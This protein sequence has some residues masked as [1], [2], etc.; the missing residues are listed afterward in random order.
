M[1]DGQLII[2]D[3]QC[4]IDKHA[5]EGA[6]GAQKILDDRLVYKSFEEFHQSYPHGIRIALSART[7]KNR[8]SGPL[9]QT[10]VRLAQSSPVDSSPFFLLFGPEDHGLDG[11]IIRQC[12]STNYLPT[13]G[14]MK[15]LNLAQAVLLTLYIFNEYG[16]SLSDGLVDSSEGAVNAEFPDVALKKVLHEIGFNL[17]SPKVNAFNSMKTMILQGF[18]TGKQLGLFSSVLHQVLR[19]ISD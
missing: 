10:L 15:S 13:N 12:H 8:P 3:P 4:E 17:D 6:A 11:E 7:G 1:A 9:K 5:Y 18:P 16:P 14:P 2:I 19:K